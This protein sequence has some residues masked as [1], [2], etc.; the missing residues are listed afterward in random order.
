KRFYGFI[1]T[2]PPKDHCDDHR[3]QPSLNR[4]FEKCFADLCTRVDGAEYVTTGAMIKAWDG[5]KRF[6]LGAFAAARR[7]KKDKRVVSH[8][9]RT[10]LILQK[11][12]ARQALSSQAKSRDPV[13]LSTSSQRD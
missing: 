6:A 4:V 7:A 9:Q 8:H 1:H 11:A 10:P 5:A 3:D 12:P 13:A 2:E